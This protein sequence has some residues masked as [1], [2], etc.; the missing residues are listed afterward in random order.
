MLTSIREA[1][2][3][4]RRMGLD[5]ELSEHAALVVTELGTNAM[6][7]AGGI[8]AIRLVLVRG[9]RLRLEVEDTSSTPPS[10]TPGGTMSGRGLKIVEALAE[11]WGSQIRAQGKVVWAELS[12]GRTR[13]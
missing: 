9:G 11:R 6:L 12:P 8:A 10:L 3:E 1:R 13:R 5:E 7:H 4:I 2:I